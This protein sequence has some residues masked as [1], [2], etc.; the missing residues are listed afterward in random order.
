MVEATIEQL[1]TVGLLTF[2][3]ANFI[4]SFQKKLDGKPKTETELWAEQYQKDVPTVWVKP[5]SQ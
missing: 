3:F 1:F 2:M 4:I 5:D